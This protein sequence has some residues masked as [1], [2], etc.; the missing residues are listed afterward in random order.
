MHYTILNGLEKMLFSQSPI[1]KEYILRPSEHCANITNEYENKVICLGM[2]S[3]HAEIITIISYILY[4][5]KYVS[6]IFLIVSILV[7]CIQR[8]VTKRHTI[9]QVIIG[10]IIGVLYGEL[11]FKTKLSAYSIFITILFIILIST[12]LL[13]LID[14]RIKNTK[15]PDWVDK[16]MYKRIKEKQNIN[17]I[18][19]L[20]SIIIPSYDQEHSLFIN[21]DLLEKHLDN[22]VNK[23]KGTNIR[24]DGVVGIKTGGAI[25]SDY[26]SNK[27]NIPNYKIKVST[28]DNNCN[29]T[30][31]KSIKTSTE[32]YK[33]NIHKEFMMCET[34]NE[35]LSNKNIILIDET[36]ASGGTIKKSIDY[37]IDD[38]KVNEIFACCIYN[39]Y[40]FNDHRN[41]KIHSQQKPG[42]MCFI[43]PWG[44]D[45]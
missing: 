22:I 12:C 24:Y 9:I 25:I 35:N 38:K 32:M 2:P 42:F 8:I 6:L 43:L 10:S 13:F 17:I 27:L 23:I 41:I 1:P 4:K 33:L 11:Y 34:I 39:T 29:K 45:N 19:K 5:Y 37:L 16:K 44:Y 7:V 15:I 31:F 40:N 28:V 3:G 14:S 30:D 26:I 21:W 18:T 20:G 36:V